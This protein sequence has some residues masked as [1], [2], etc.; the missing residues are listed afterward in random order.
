MSGSQPKDYCYY[1]NNTVRKCLQWAA[2]F[3][4]EAGG[5]GYNYF[6]QCKFNDTT[7]GRGKLPY[8]GYEGHG[9][10]IN[11]DMHHAVLDQCEM[12]GNGRSGSCC[13]VDCAWP[14]RRCP[15]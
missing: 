8:P 9:F 6:Y 12:A 1:A 10:R 5:I 13:S 3:Q 7:V 14:R 4:G 11:G 2:Q 15:W